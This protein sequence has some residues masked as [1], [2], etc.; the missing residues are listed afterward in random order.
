[1]KNEL[2]K[3]YQHRF[4][5]QEQNQKNK[6]WK[7]ICKYLEESFFK[8]INLVSDSVIVDVAA[9]YC[10]FINNIYQNKN[11]KKW[12]IDANP[13]IENYATKD[14][15]V[16]NDT[17]ENL[18]HCFK[19]DSVFMFFQSNF[20]EHLTKSQIVQLFKDEFNLLQKGGYCCILTPNIRYC[21]GKYWDFFDHITPLTEK[22]LIEQAEATG[23]ILK[24]CITK[25]LPYTTKS[26][27]PKA[28][29]L[30]R[31]YLKLLPF[32]GWILGEQSLILLQKP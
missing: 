25:F 28:P 18:H 5:Q 22:S 31:I 11:I 1:M 30:V 15:C 23:F 8:E 10:D 7:Q 14:V 12:A 9:G 29:W 20:L 26:K 17:V 3:L 32:S 24:K 16:Y 6:I 13:D 27:I 2:K 21:G 19:T 4:N